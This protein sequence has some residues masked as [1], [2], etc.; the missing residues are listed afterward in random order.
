MIY[1]DFFS[2]NSH[3]NNGKPIE[4]TRRLFFSLWYQLHGKDIFTSDWERREREQIKEND[5][6]IKV[7]TIM[8]QVLII[9]IVICILIRKKKKF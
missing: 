7:K 2:S 8:Y 6:K 4:R 5:L 1:Q 3:K 9:K